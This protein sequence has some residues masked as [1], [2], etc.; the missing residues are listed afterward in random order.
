MGLPTRQISQPAPQSAVRAETTIMA[1]G[2]SLKIK[3]QQNTMIMTTN[4]TSNL[5]ASHLRVIFT[6][7]LRYV[8]YNNITW[9]IFCQENPQKT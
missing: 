2:G 8:R 1:M 4:A 5:C 6:T 9:Q 3:A 7:F